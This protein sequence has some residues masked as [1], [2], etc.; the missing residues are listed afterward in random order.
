[1][2]W[3][4][5]GACRTLAAPE[6]TNARHT[7]TV[8][9]ANRIVLLF[10]YRSSGSFRTAGNAGAEAL[11]A[12]ALRANF[13]PIIAP[14]IDVASDL[15]MRRAMMR[16]IRPATCVA[17]FDESALNPSAAQRSADIGLRGISDG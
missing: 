15:G 3:A 13:F 4:M 1:M 14:I 7:M 5:C 16:F 11:D 9:I 17:R 8:A 12:I 10:I 2:S 6:P